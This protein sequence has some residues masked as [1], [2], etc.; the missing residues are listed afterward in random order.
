MHL[1]TVVDY[2]VGRKITGVSSLLLLK[3]SKTVSGCPARSKALGGGSVLARLPMRKLPVAG[4][5]A[6]SS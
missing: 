5:L 3:R 1:H 6:C 4:M 2:R